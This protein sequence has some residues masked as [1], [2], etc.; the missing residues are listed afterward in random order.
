MVRVCCH[1]FKERTNLFMNLYFELGATR[2]VI[3]DGYKYLSFK[4]PQSIKN[5]LEKNG[6]RHSYL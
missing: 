6:K 2:A 3:K 4:A 1:Y 5:K